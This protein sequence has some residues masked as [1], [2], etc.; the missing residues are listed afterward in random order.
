MARNWQDWTTCLDTKRTKRSCISHGS[1][2]RHILVAILVIAGFAMRQKAWLM[3]AFKS[4]R[5]TLRFSWGRVST[6]AQC[7]SAFCRKTVEQ[8]AGNKDEVRG[9]PAPVAS[10][11]L[12]C[13]FRVEATG[14]THAKHPTLLR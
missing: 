13:A 8:E 1:S 4:R 2:V 6:L 7:M 12:Q 14:C 10:P 11:L 5:N 9:K 3:E